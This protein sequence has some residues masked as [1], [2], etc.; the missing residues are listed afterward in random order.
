M[1]PGIPRIPILAALLLAAFPTLAQSPFPSGTTVLGSP[2]SMDSGWKRCVV[3][4]PAQ[5]YSGYALECAD[6]VMSPDGKVRLMRPMTVEAKWVK[7]DNPSFR[8]DMQIAKIREEMANRDKQKSARAASAKAASAKPNGAAQ[9]VALGK[10]EC[11]AFN[12]AR[13]LL[14]FTATAP[15]KYTASDGSR[16]TFTYDAASG[17][18]EFKGYLADSM[19]KGYSTKYHEPKGRPTVSFRS[20][21]GAEVSFCE[22]V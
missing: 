13:M 6:E 15:G 4:K 7:A 1:T 12:S 2:N 17:R 3:I 18:L 8:P 19:P 22:K 11:W 10:Y 9:S 21:R 16:S 5:G 20:A 14:N